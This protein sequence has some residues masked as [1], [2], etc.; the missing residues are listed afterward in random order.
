M[1]KTSLY[2]WIGDELWSGKPGIITAILKGHC[3]VPLISY[4]PEIAKQSIALID[5]S[6][7]HKNIKLIRLE[8]VETIITVE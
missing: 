2:A 4:D 6:L 5:R 3:P 8:E 7:G 1:E